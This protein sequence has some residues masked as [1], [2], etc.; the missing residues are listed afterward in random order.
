MKKKDQLSYFR[1]EWAKLKADLK[2]FDKKGKQEALHRFRVQVKKLRAFLVLADS[3]ENVHKLEKQLKPVRKIFKAGGVIRNAYMT[4]ELSKEYQQ[5]PSAFMRGQRRLMKESAALFRSASAKHLARVRQTRRRLKK[6]V[7]RFSNVHISMY[8]QQQLEEIALC[9]KPRRSE[10]SL[11]D[12]RKQIKM[13]IYNYP[14]V[15]PVLSL[16]FNEVYL[17]QVQTAIGDWHDKQVAIELFSSEEVG[18]APVAESLKKEQTQLK[19]KI[20]GLVKD[21]YN[22]ATTVVDLPLNQ[23]D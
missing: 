7:P 16:A 20:R 12:C 10:A 3:G 14:L 15:K 11:H 22:R 1:H 17:E 9:L 13:L 5:R 23:I 2:T 18:A 6:A 8:Y 21:F 19:T 4:L